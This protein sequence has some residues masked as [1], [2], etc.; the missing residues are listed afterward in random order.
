MWS[1]TA[2][3]YD[4]LDAGA[5]AEAFGIPKLRQALIDAAYGQVLEVAVGVCP[6]PIP[7]S[8]YTLSCAHMT[9]CACS[10]LFAH[11]ARC[12]LLSFCPFFRLL[13]QV[14]VNALAMV[15]RFS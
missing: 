8:A 2:A 13:E 14:L 1:C 10:R 11:H 6:Q 7:D 4:R 5:A 12:H 3:H 9:H 15:L